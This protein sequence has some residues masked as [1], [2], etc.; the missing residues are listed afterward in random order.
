MRAVK[1][2]NQHAAPTHPRTLA[3]VLA[4]LAL[5]LLV[6]AAPY[7]A[8]ARD[9]KVAKDKKQDKKAKQA[10]KRPL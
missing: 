6:L 1:N 2:R 5:G 10:D 3:G 7:F 8:A 4:L 9:Q